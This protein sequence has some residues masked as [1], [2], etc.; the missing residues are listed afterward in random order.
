MIHH[1]NWFNHWKKEIF[2]IWFDLIVFFFLDLEKKVAKCHHFVPFSLYPF[3]LFPLFSSFLL[4]PRTET[5]LKAMCSFSL[6]FFF[7]SVIWLISLFPLSL[8]F[9]FLFS[10]SLLSF[11]LLFWIYGFSDLYFF[12]FLFF[13]PVP[14]CFWNF[15]SVPLPFWVRTPNIPSNI[16]PFSSL[17]ASFSSSSCFSSSFPLSFPF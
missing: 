5:K 13:L 3:F 2:N 15:I 8:S 12:L 4:N 7:L 10:C 17:F 16:P 9:S 6:F 11:H 14:F 1:W